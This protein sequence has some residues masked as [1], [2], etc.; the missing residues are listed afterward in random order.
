MSLRRHR[1]HGRD[2]G[3]PSRRGFRLCGSVGPGADARR[4]PDKLAGGFRRRSSQALDRLDPDGWS[5]AI[6]CEGNQS[7]AA[8]RWRA[9]RTLL[10]IQNERSAEKTQRCLRELSATS[11]KSLRSPSK[12]SAA[13]SCSPAPTTPVRLLSALRSQY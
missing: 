8:L 10:N 4:A 6:R 3:G 11:A 12:V 2:Q 13:D 9:E 7:E 5:S 1:A